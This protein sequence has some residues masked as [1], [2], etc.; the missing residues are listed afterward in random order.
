[1]QRRRRIRGHLYD[2][3]IEHQQPGLEEASFAAFFEREYPRLVRLLFAMT[4]DMYEAED[5][6]QEAMTRTFQ[7]WDQVRTMETAG[8]YVYRTALNLHRKRIR[9][10]QVRARRLVLLRARPPMEAHVPGEIVLALRLLPEGQRA[11]LLLV[12]W[13]GMTAEE[14][15]QVLGV[16]A[17]SVRSRIAR[18]RRTL[19]ARE[20]DDD[21]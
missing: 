2:V 10:L 18:A 11:A 12:E 7:R 20:E 1:M 9:H 19:A 17:S 14:A 13:L 6:A 16:A 3:P 4:S 8:G 5:L 15:G 21:A